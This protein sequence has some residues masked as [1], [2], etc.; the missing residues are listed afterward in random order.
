LVEVFL[1]A[2]DFDG[3]FDFAAAGFLAVAD[4]VDAVFFVAD[5][6]LL[7]AAVFGFAAPLAFALDLVRVA[8]VF[9][10][11]AARFAFADW[12]AVGFFGSGTDAGFDVI[13][14]GLEY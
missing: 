14:E 10:A 9:L 4:F 7:E 12:V 11:A 8:G 2:E 5:V 1:A 6:D 13:A 3:V